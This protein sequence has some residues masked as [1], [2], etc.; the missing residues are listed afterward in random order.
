MASLIL[1]ERD[2]QFLL[3]EMLGVDRL[4]DAPKYA[5]FSKD[6]FEMIINEAQK[7]A[8]EEIFPTLTESDKEG[9]RLENGSVKVPKCFHR[10][11][12]LYCDAGWGSMCFP[13]EEGG[14][15]LPASIRTAAH[16][17]FIHNFAFVAYPGLGE[18]AAH[19]VEVYGTLEQKHKYLPKMISGEWGGTMC[20]TEP[21]AGTDVGNLSTK[22]IRQPD[23]TYKIV[24]TK[25]FITSG[26][27]DLVSNIVHPVLARIEGDPAGTKGIS[28]FLVPKYLVNDDGSL[29]RRNDYEI[30]KI[31]EK[32]GIHGSAT[33]LMNFGDNG[34][35]YAELLGQER[36]GMK[37]MFQLMNE[38]RLGVGLQGVASASIAYQHAVRYAKDRLQGSSLLEFKNPDAPRISIINHPD[39]RRMLLWMKAHVDGMRAMAY[40]VAYSF[41]KFLIAADDADKEKWIGHA[42]IITPI[43]KAYCSDMSFKVIENA[44]QI[45]GGYGFCSEYPIEQF[46]RDEKI[47]SIYE[48]ANGIQALDLVGRKMGMKKGAYFMGMLGEMGSC[49]QKYSAELPELA[50][51]VQAGVNAIAEMGMFFAKCA[52]EGKF[53]VPV[54]NAYP[55]LM[56]MG[57]VVVAWLLFW[58]AGI[59]REKLSALCAGKGVDAADAVKVAALIKDSRDAAFYSGKIASAKY[60]IKNVLPEIDAV[61][62]AI[63]SEDMSILEI[64]EESF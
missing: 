9:C 10:V 35:C 16:E 26:D 55:F 60:F 45:Y 33:C 36:E 53:L 21:G 40:F 61:V 17:W 23:G 43:L 34:N 47:A 28:I 25:M 13:P 51:D 20:L 6:M 3:F 52:K 57:R 44:M 31:E 56:M 14:Q 38:A 22:A 63:K 59:A 27:H 8:T 2:Q 7:F 48:G 15:G 46:M 11:Y 32:M 18:G 58:E 19:L 62:K 29:G 30:A 37:V 54:N 5:E 39:I 4:C 64:A 1:D 49:V 24:G 42:E 12:K 50:Q 41:D